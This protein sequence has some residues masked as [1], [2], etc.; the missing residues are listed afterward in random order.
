MGYTAH[1]YSLNEPR[2]FMTPVLSRARK[3]LHTALAKRAFMTNREQ[4][5]V[6]PRGNPSTWFFD[7]R[8]I[9]LDGPVLKDAADL[10]WDQLK[11]MLPF[12]VG[13]LETAAI[14]L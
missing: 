3:Q 2:S 9:I 8:S 1:H 11:P 14:A 6:S 10:L 5:M 12:Q 13:G 4:R 7:F